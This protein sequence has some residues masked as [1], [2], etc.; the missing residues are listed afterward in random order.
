MKSSTRL[1]GSIA[2][3]PILSPSCASSLSNSGLSNFRDPWPRK[4]MPTQ[5]RNAKDIVLIVDD[6]PDNLAV[7]T[8]ALDDAG[9]MVLVATDGETALDRLQHITPDI[10][11]LDA[12][13]PRLDGFET[14]RR[15]KQL[16]ASRWIPV[17]FMT[18]LTETE[19]IVRGF[20]AGGVDYVTKPI[21]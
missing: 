6:T 2:A 8:D 15:L 4:A 13:M 14:C 18:G 11:L 3:T 9:Y 1:S 10:I 17:V 7:L 16:E 12:V 19:D 20:R 21:R 5:E